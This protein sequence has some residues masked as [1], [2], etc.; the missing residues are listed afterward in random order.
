[1]ENEP[2]L[3]DVSGSAVLLSGSRSIFLAADPGLGQKDS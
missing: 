3:A 1:M 2:P